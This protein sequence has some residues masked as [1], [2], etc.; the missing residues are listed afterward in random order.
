MPV[1]EQDG[2]GEVASVVCGSTA[3]GTRHS[4]VSGRHQHHHSA[5]RGATFVGSAFAAPIA[6]S[7]LLRAIVDLAR[8]LGWKW[9]GR[10]GQLAVSFEQALGSP[11]EAHEIVDVLHLLMAAER[12][13][14]RVPEV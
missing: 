13:E 10:D 11:P 3:P 12:P 7:A 14:R 2:C 6:A 4:C 1:V 8:N 5:L 9:I